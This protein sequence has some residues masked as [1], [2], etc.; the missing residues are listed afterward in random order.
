TLLKAFREL[1]AARDT[2]PNDLG[3]ALGA[4]AACVT[5]ASSSSFGT[6]FATALMAA[7]KTL[8]SRESAEWAELP[9]L[10]GV[11]I[12]AM[13]SRGKAQLGD[14]TV[15]DALAAAQ[16]ATRGLS[17]PAIMLPAALSAISA[18][19]VEFTNKPNR[20]G[21]ARIFG[22]KTVG[23]P[24]PGMTAIKVMTELLAD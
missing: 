11:A 5:R 20:I 3:K 22:D 16:A 13:S 12:D 15:L 17:D 9:E 23:I 18:S 10:I 1:D 4:S 8:K 24:D 7:G 21:R 14:K 19:V 2:M 6:L